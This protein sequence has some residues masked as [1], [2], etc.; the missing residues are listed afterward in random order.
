MS[1]IVKIR[2][3]LDFNIPGSS[4][5]PLTYKLFYLSKDEREQTSETDISELPLFSYHVKYSTDILKKLSHAECVRTFFSKTLFEER[6]MQYNKD[7]ITDKDTQHDNAKHNLKVMVHFLFP[8]VYPVR[9]NIHSTFDEMIMKQSSDIDR[10]YSLLPDF[11]ERL[12]RQNVDYANAVLYVQGG[13][14]SVTGVTIVDDIVHSP[15]YRNY[16]EKLRQF[17]LWRTKKLADLK[18]SNEKQQLEIV[19]LFNKTLNDVK[20][21]E[22]KKKIDK[23]MTGIISKYERATTAGVDPEILKKMLDG[24]HSELN[25]T[26][27]NSNKIQNLLF[28]IYKLNNRKGSYQRSFLPNTLETREFVYL[29]DKNAT[30]KIEKTIIDEYFANPKRIYDLLST[31][32]NSN[33]TTKD[34]I[35]EAIRGKLKKYPEWTYVFELIKSMMP[36]KRFVTNTKLQDVLGSF[37]NSNA[38]STDLLQLAED[39]S[40]YSKSQRAAD[41]LDQYTKK[42]FELGVVVISDTNKP[43]T[44]KEFTFEVD[45]NNIVEVYLL[46][47]LVKGVLTPQTL[48]TIQCVYKNAVLVEKYKEFRHPN[49]STTSIYRPP[50]LNI[51]SMEKEEQIKKTKQ[52]TSRKTT[53]PTVAPNRTRRQPSGKVILGGFVP[54]EHVPSVRLETPRAQISSGRNVRNRRKKGP[55]SRKPRNVRIIP[56]PL[57][58]PVQQD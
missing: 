45:E 51:D 46:T 15:I 35:T 49:K 52:A 38:T 33:Q 53:G 6:V 43:K 36:P 7:L 54:S 31:T 37:I 14:Y 10:S 58:S 11:I 29:L 50:L 57:P 55:H 25:K 13:A 2:L 20:T 9:D 24:L 22:G 27:T 1:N 40:T 30:C 4:H 17:G 48:K 26:P 16:M 21:D 23:E 5:T 42:L 12:F 34:E 28:E 32:P 47:D 8:I 19:E 39:V 41:T 18:K 3:L 56:Y 44:K